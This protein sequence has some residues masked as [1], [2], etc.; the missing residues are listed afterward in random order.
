M[1]IFGVFLMFLF[2]LL[3]KLASLVLEVIS[4]FHAVHELLHVHSKGQSPISVE[5][6]EEI[7]AEIPS[8][9]GNDGAA[10]VSLL[11]AEVQLIASI[12]LQEEDARDTGRAV[13]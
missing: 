9:P 4:L 11:R 12:T 10:F 5:S 2:E 3:F 13:G 1:K 8:V 7:L 6:S